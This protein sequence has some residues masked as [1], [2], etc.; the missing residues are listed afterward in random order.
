MGAYLINCLHTFTVPVMIQAVLL[1]LLNTTPIWEVSAQQINYDVYLNEKQV[2]SLS[3]K[4]STKDEL[5]NYWI[6][7]DVNFRFIFKMNMNYTFE[8]VFQNDMLIRAFTKN[9]VNDDEKSSS[10]VTW[11]GKFYQMEVKNEQTVLK[12]T[13]ITYSMAMLYFREPRNVSQVFSERYAR[14]LAIKPLKEHYYE[15]TMPDGKKNF[16]SYANGLCQ[17]VEVQHTVGKISFK[18]KNPR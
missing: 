7:S 18:I 16:Y 5:I 4:R 9:V 2:G 3:A 15:L 10:K 8:T 1:L 14:F 13:R 6:E 17:L 12:N 11:N